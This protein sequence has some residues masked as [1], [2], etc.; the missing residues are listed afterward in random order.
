MLDDDTALNHNHRLIDPGGS[1]YELIEYTQAERID[2][3][4]IATVIKLPA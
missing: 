3:L 2:T 1:I 4:P